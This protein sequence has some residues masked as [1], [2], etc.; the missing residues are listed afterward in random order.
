MISEEIIHKKEKRRTPSSYTL[1][2]LAVTKTG[3]VLLVDIE[4]A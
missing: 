2:E 3:T 4:A 1:A